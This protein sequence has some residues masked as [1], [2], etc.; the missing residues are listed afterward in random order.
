MNFPTMSQAT[1]GWTYQTLP[2]SCYFINFWGD[3]ANP[4]VN[5][6]PDGK[7]KLL[8]VSS[9]LTIPVGQS[10]FMEVRAPDNIGH[11]FSHFK[12]NTDAALETWHSI[13]HNFQDLIIDSSVTIQLNGQCVNNCS[14][15][16]CLFIQNLDNLTYLPE[17]GKYYQRC[18]IL[19][20]LRGECIHGME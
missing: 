2:N 7:Y 18:G 15:V 13:N 8:S 1:Y 20:W 16:L 14:G 9:Y 6:T 12:V 3:N 5:W 11:Y 19:E 4:S 10:C 17:T